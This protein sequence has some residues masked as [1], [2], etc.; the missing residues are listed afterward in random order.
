MN[1]NNQNPQNEKPNKNINEQG[2]LSKQ[3]PDLN[4][5]PKKVLW[6]KYF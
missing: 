4:T 1:T 3:D 2:G 6:E 5:L